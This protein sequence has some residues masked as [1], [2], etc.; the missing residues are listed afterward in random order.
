MTDATTEPEDN[1]TPGGRDRKLDYGNAPGKEDKGDGVRAPDDIEAR[2]AAASVR[3]E[4]A[5]AEDA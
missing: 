1:A 3:G 5:S 2:V 4:S